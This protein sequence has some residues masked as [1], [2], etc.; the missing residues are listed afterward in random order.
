MRFIIVDVD[1]DQGMLTSEEEGRLLA[2]VKRTCQEDGRVNREI[3]SAVYLND[4]FRTNKMTWGFTAL[5]LTSPAVTDEDIVAYFM[6]VLESTTL[7][8]T[9]SM[10]CSL[11]DIYDHDRC[12]L[13]I[14]QEGLACRF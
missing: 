10:T 3:L 6:Y 8:S 4:M 12:K 11:R 5:V 7:G 13:Q 14:T 2:R 1:L 9:D